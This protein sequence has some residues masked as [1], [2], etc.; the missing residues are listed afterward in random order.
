MDVLH[1]EIFLPPDAPHELSDPQIF[2]DR[3]DSAETRTDSRTLRT[4]RASLPNELSLH[5]VY[6]SKHEALDSYRDLLSVEDLSA[7]FMV[8]KQT[9][10]K[11]LKSGEF[12]DPIQ[13]GRAYRIPK[14]YILQRY[15]Q[16]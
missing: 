5:E 15:F 16:V 3:V 9:I 12:G 14:I 1:K 11:A 8:S 6:N 13:I 4:I 2:A 7:I 10:Y